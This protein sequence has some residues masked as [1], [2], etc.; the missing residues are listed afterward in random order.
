MNSRDLFISSENDNQGIDVNSLRHQPRDINIS[1][2]GYHQQQ[3][4]YGNHGQQPLNLRDYSTPAPNLTVNNDLNSLGL[5]L[6]INPK[7]KSDAASILSSSQSDLS[8][9]DAQGYQGRPTYQQHAYSSRSGSDEEDD[10]DASSVTS[11]R[12]SSSNSSRRSARRAH[13]QPRMLTEEDILNKKK[14]LLYQFDRLEKKG[15]RV[16]RKFT[17]ASSLEEMQQEYDRLVR[18]REVDASVNFQR[19]IMMAAVTG[20][21]L[22]NNKFDPF[23]VKLDGWSESIHENI[24]DYDEVFEEL[25]EKYKG[26]GQ[27][28]PELRLI[29]MLGGSAFMFHMTNTM[30]K[31]SLPG[32]DQVLKQNPDLMKQFASATANT[33]AQSGND[34]TGLSGLFS[35]MFQQG[36]PPPTSSNNGMN[37]AGMGAAKPSNGAVPPP[38]MARPQM[39]GPSNIDNYLKNLEAQSM[40]DRLET[41]STLTESEISE[42]PDN[43]SISGLVIGK[44]KQGKRTL[45]I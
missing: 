29:M 35:N 31:S 44:N 6:L 23:A 13:Q 39:R 16:P 7:K 34:T 32:L 9:D 38:S 37:G 20:I 18:D 2:Q 5:D 25:H 11:S 3:Q 24:Y 27:L 30:F 1:T 12:S 45:N 41:L 26:R 43:A 42:L 14:E 40:N 15:H 36:P 21:E 22:L 19:K 4:S 10:D 28:A 33:M 17:L 8:N